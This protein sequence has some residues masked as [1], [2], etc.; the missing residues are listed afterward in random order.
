[1]KPHFDTNGSDGCSV[2]RLLRL[3]LPSEPGEQ[4]ECCID[5]DAAYYRGG[6]RRDRAIAD[7]ELLLGLLRT[8]MDV[9]RAEQYHT[10]V[11]MLGK[12]HWCDGRT[13]DDWRQG[14]G[15]YSDDPPD[16]R[17]AIDSLMD[18]GGFLKRPVYE[19]A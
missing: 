10:A 5:H 7:A 2:P 6:S 4:R 15:L 14:M 17:P 19:D 16:T 13:G 9:D 18:A 1:M 3:V 11:R 8:G 12:P